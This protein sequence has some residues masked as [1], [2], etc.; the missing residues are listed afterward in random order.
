MTA[1]RL[2]TTLQWNLSEKHGVFASIGAELGR[3]VA[4]KGTGL[5]IDKDVKSAPSFE[6]GYR[7]RF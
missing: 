4:I 6:V 1:Y 5:D 2:Y 7:F 3:E